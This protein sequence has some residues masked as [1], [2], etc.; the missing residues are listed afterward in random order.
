MKIRLNMNLEMDVEPSEIVT[1]ADACNKSL[2]EVFNTVTNN[3]KSDNK[4]DET[5][6]DTV[7]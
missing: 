4:T 7:E 6:E 2:N 5:K 3:D 1:L